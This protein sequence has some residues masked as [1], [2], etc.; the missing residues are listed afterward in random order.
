MHSCV[1]LFSGRSRLVGVSDAPR[2]PRGRLHRL[3]DAALKRL[4][5]L[6]G[7]LKLVF[8][9][10][11]GVLP[12]SKASSAAKKPRKAV[13]ARPRAA[14][15]RP[16]KVTTSA[17]PFR[18]WVPRASHLQRPRPH[19]RVLCVRAWAAAP[20]LMR[21]G[22]CIVS[23]ARRGG[24]RVACFAQGTRADPRVCA[25]IPGAAIALALK[26]AIVHIY[27]LSKRVFQPSPLAGVA[28]T[29]GAAFWMLSNYR[30]KKIV[31][32]TT[33]GP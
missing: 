19:L 13:P 30:A 21:R 4:L 22:F 10:W 1:R 5:R 26:T 11:A 18:T 33:A 14:H 6:F 17:R 31:C 25:R 15:V 23:R 32:S 3:A 20:T 12:N 8:A 24:V 27:Q 2:K 9:L 29:S 7:L 28:V 16:G